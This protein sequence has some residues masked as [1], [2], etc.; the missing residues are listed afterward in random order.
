MRLSLILALC[1]A[2]ATAAAASD[3]GPSSLAGRFAIAV[4]N[5]AALE[6]ILAEGAVTPAEA[7]ELAALKGCAPVQPELISKNEFGLQWKCPAKP[8]HVGRT[9]AVVRVKDGMVVKVLMSKVERQ[10][11]IF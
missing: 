11:G 3:L 2:P 10:E 5:G 8:R 7:T 6:E 1:V 4:A 9:A